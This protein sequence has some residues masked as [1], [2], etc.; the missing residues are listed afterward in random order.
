V[1]QASQYLGYVLDDQDL[2]QGEVKDFSVPPLGTGGRF[3]RGVKRLGREAD[4]SPPSSAEVKNG[5][6]VPPL[7]HMSSW[8]SA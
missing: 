4:Q 1:R 2:I 7:P 5:W 6:T 3:P 8:H